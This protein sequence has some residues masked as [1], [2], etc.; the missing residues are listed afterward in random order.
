AWGLLAVLSLVASGLAYEVAL[1]LFLLTPLLVWCRGRQLQERDAGQ[2]LAAATTLLALLA[3]VAFKLGTTT[4]LGNHGS[5]PTHV[6]A[7]SRRARSFG[8]DPEYGLNIAKAIR[9]SY[10]DYGIQL[11]RLAWRIL[12]DH[13]DPAV[14]GVAAMLAVLVFGYLYRATRRQ[15]GG[16]PGRDVLLACVALGALTFGLGY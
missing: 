8:A 9:L 14:V 3:V 2:P 15:G 7:L 5:L 4:R 12:R 13:P 11:P 1:P 10:G 6:L 16:L